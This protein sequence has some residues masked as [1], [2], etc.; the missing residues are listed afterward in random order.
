MHW[1]RRRTAV[2]VAAIGVGG[3][4]AAAVALVGSSGSASATPQAPARRIPV[5]A[6]PSNQ[7][8][9]QSVYA[10]VGDIPNPIPDGTL[11]DATAKVSH[12]SQFIFADY[13]SNG[14]LCDVTYYADPG[15]TEPNDVSGFQGCLPQGMERPIADLHVDGG[16]A[17]DGAFVLYGSVPSEADTVEVIDLKGNKYDFAL[18]DA[19]S[20]DTNPDRQPVI[21]DLSSYG[22]TSAD[23]IIV[24]SNGKVLATIQ[25][26]A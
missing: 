4:L 20:L 21:F 12:G 18:Q 9:P 7:P 25:A 16:S 14:S 17:N 26:G 3:V 15:T 19:T 11:I 2:V 8:L 22:I 10:D 24:L 13:G 1:K 6:Q 23:Q 5:A